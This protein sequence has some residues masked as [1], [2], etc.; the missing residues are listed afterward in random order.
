MLWRSQGIYCLHCSHPQGT[1]ARCHNVPG[2]TRSSVPESML[3]RIQLL[4]DLYVINKIFSD[5]SFHRLNDVGCE[6][7]WSEIWWIC[8]RNLYF[9]MK[10]KVTF[11]SHCLRATTEKLHYHQAI[12]NIDRTILLWHLLIFFKNWISP[13]QPTIRK[14]IDL[15]SFTLMFHMFPLSL[16]KGRALIKIYP[17]LS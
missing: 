10:I 7:N 3:G 13:S 6:G 1:Q 8:K 2:K 14:S 11:D 15:C 12:Q 9:V 5:N 17:S 4:M 16:Y